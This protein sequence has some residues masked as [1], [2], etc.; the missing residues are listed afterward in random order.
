[1]FEARLEFYE[2]DG[3]GV[4]VG[5]ETGAPARLGT[6]GP[7]GTLGSEWAGTSNPGGGGRPQRGE[8]GCVGVDVPRAKVWNRSHRKGLA[9]WVW[10]WGHCGTMR[11][12]LREKAGWEPRHCLWPGVYD[13]GQRVRTSGAALRDS[14]TAVGRCAFASGL[15]VT[16][17]P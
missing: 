2:V 9:V 7:Q 10:V 15:D 4:G 3:S 11:P 17:A 16:L 13:P 14:R 8:R 5:G 12:C 1:M 6:R